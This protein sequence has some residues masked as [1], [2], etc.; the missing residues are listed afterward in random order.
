M[1]IEDPGTLEP[2][3]LARRTSQAAM[4]VACALVLDAHRLVGPSAVGE[5]IRRRAW[6]PG[7]SSAHRTKS[8]STDGGSA[9]IGHDPAVDGL[10]PDV[11][12]AE[13][14]QRQAGFM[15][16]FARQRLDG[17]HHGGGEPRGRPGRGSSARPASSLSPAA[18][19]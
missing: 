8:P 4:Q 3:T 19:F 5:C 12:A 14:R 2:N 9:D 18:C 1:A 17:N 6:M 16:E 7:F 10:A 15:G 11:D 13:A